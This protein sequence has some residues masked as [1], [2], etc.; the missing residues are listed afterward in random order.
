ME[1][2]IANLRTVQRLRELITTQLKRHPLT[3]MVGASALIFFVCSSL[4]HSLFESTAFDLGIYDQVAYLMSQGLPPISSFLDIHHLGN[5]AAWSFYALGPLYALYPS[6]HWLFA[7]QAL[8]L[9]AGAWPSWGLARQAGLQQGQALA[10]AAVYLLYP[11]VFNVNLFDFHPEVMAIPA[12]LGAILAARLDRPLWFTLGIL[13]VLGCKDA[14][15]LLVAAMGVWLFFFEKKRRCGAIALFAG[16][17]WFLFVTQALIPHFKD[18]GGPGALGRYGYLGDSVIEMALNLILKP[19]LVL[20]RVFSLDTLEYLVLLS[21][22]I[23]WGLVPRYFAP[24]VSIL[25]T[26]GLNILSDVGEQRDLIHQYSLPLLPFLLLVLIASLASGRAW[27]KRGRWIVVWS[28]VSFLCLAKFGYFWSIYLDTIDTRRASQM[29]VAQVE[30]TGGVVTT[31][32]IAPHLSHRPTIELQQTVAN[33][34]AETLAAD[35]Q[36]VLLN[37]RHPGWD[38]TIEVSTALRDRLQ[39]APQFSLRYQQDDVYLFER[40]QN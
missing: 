27:L 15:S 11:V 35:F 39:A 8:S 28:L 18:G 6:V 30:G 34:D 23:L 33:A 40:N 29:A 22:P 21:A 24:L 12:L 13:F 2:A 7:V 26:L 25:P 38:S 37:L 9:A 4:R 5:H 17:A 32:A 19:G 16:T 36:Y 31:A 20:G 1:S 3:W 14:L 10:I